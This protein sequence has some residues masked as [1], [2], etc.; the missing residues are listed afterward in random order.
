[1][2]QGEA[3]ANQESK[4]GLPMNGLDILAEPQVCKFCESVDQFIAYRH[5]STQGGV[6]H[7][8]AWIQ[9]MVCGEKRDLVPTGNA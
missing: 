5:F 4:G 9:C 7:E 6:K 2:S 8:V 1:M 3:Q